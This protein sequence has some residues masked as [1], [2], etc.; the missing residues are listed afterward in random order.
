MAAG[1]H[2]GMYRAWS[3]REEHAGIAGVEERV[4]VKQHSF[5]CRTGPCNQSFSLI[6]QKPL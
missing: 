1:E 5:P 6:F 3:E 4:K 2:V